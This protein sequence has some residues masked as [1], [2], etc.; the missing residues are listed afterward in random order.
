MA[1]GFDHL[2]DATITHL[3]ALKAEGARS[4]PFSNESVQTLREMLQEQRE[5]AEPAH[6]NRPFVKSPY[7]VKPFRVK[8][9]RLLLMQAKPRFLI[10]WVRPPI[11]RS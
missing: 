8:R 10:W 3:E 6:S 1:Q 9:A 2:L 11:G 4:V 7:R 5:R